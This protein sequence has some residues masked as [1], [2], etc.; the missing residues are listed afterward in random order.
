MTQVTDAGVTTRQINHSEMLYRPG[1]RDL[2]IRFFEAL[3]CAVNEIDAGALG[4]YLVI[5]IEPSDRNIGRNSF[6]CSEVR[7]AQWEFEQELLRQLDDASSALAIARRP[8]R[9]MIDTQAYAAGHI[10]IRTP[11]TAAVHEVLDRVRTTK[12]F[13]GRAAV[14]CILEPEGDSDGML[15]IQAFVWTDIVSASLLSIGQ[16]FEL[17]G[18]S[19][20]E[21]DLDSLPE[22]VTLLS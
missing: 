19:G 17:Q 18:D 5:R 4:R 7:P 8:F 3:G 1:E 14:A 10:G 13:D 6:Y 15:P 16:V 2:A 9:E 20:V 21:S 22:G 12:D 11:S